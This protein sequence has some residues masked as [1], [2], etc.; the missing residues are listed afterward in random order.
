MASMTVILKPENYKQDNLQHLDTLNEASGLDIYAIKGDNTRCI[1]YIDNLTPPAII[2]SVKDDEISTPDDLGKVINDF[3]NDYGLKKGD[4]IIEWFFF[5][6]KEEL[7][8]KAFKLADIS[9]RHNLDK[10]FGSFKCISYDLPSDRGVY[11][12][13]DSTLLELRQQIAR[14]EYIDSVAK[15]AHYSKSAKYASV[16]ANLLKADPE[17]VVFVSDYL[18]DKKR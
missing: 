17:T 3:F 9:T 12:K 8:E 7:A 18:T 10:M 11:V 6:D 2:L 13:A 4:F 15:L 1:A 5:M 16:V 14:Q